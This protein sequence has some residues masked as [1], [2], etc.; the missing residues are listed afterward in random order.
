M[1]K[2]SR[3]F[4]SL[5]VFWLARQHSLNTSQSLVITLLSVICCLLPPI[6]EAAAF[7]FSIPHF[8]LN[9]FEWKAADELIS[10]DI[11]LRACVFCA[12]ASVTAA[13]GFLISV[14]RALDWNIFSVLD[15][16]NEETGEVILFMFCSN[17][18]P[19]TSLLRWG[20]KTTLR[21]FCAMRT[22]QNPSYN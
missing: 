12:R 9:L 2:I 1:P 20:A 11:S 3:R 21:F 17:S 7:I 15:F 10:I 8:L 22:A 16:H 4:N 18:G 19:L 6:C 14:P 5:G 13:F